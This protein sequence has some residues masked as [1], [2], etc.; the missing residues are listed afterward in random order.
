MKAPSRL[1]Y[2]FRLGWS[3]GASAL[4][5]ALGEARSSASCFRSAHTVMQ[6]AIDAASVRRMLRDADAIAGRLVNLLTNTRAWLVAARL[7]RSLPC[8]PESAHAP[9]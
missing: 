4:G 8:L 5:I 3:R 1:F 9:R 2:F 7:P 6:D